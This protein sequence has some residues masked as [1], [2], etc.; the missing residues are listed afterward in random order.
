MPSDN[1][2]ERAMLNIQTKLCHWSLDDYIKLYGESDPIFC[3]V[4]NNF[5]DYYY[6]VRRSA[7]IVGELLAYQ[8]GTQYE[9][10]DIQAV[11]IKGALTEILDVC[12]KRRPKCNTLYIVSPPGTLCHHR[13]HCVGREEFFH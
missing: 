11:H 3:A 7:E 12:E 6:S 13:V 10:E 8:T 4:N 2:F 5:E 1:V 9:E